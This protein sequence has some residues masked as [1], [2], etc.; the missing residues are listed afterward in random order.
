MKEPASRSK[1]RSGFPRPSAPVRRLGWECKWPMTSGRL[2]AAPMK[3]GGG[4]LRP[5]DRSI[6]RMMLWEFR[7]RPLAVK[8]FLQRLIDAA[9]CLFPRSGPR[10]CAW[11][12]LRLAKRQGNPG[13]NVDG[14]KDDASN[15]YDL[16]RRI[17][18]L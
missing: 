16:R 9:V 2:A 12:S 4:H 7:R 1:W 14:D 3:S 11:L 6:F 17:V 15:G 5:P 13:L 8:T 10:V 18:K